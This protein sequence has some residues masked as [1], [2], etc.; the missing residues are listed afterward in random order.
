MRLQALLTEFK[1]R[2]LKVGIVNRWEQSGRN[3]VTLGDPDKFFPYPSGP[4]YPID[5]TGRSD[6]PE[7][8]AEEVK[9]IRRRFGVE[10][11]G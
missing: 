3:G 6:D 9:A 8:S 11:I 5:T 1:N 2:G 7:L 10:R 4:L